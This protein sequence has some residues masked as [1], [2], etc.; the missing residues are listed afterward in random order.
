MTA[1]DLHRPIEGDVLDL[2]IADHY[3][4]EDLLRHMRGPVAD[5]DAARQAFAAVHVAHAEAEEKLVY[6][7]LRRNAEDVSAHDA[8]HGEEEHAQ[9]NDAL[10]RVM[11]LKGV[12]TAAYDEAMTDLS[13]LVCHHLAEEELT[14]LT[15]SRA[16]VSETLRAE[17]GKKFA[18][19]RNRQIDDSCG[20]LTNLRRIVKEA[21]K[22]GLLEDEEAEIKE[23]KGES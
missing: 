21:E 5:R 19:E 6:P 2:I 12:D 13:A 22:E 9:G 23:A 3:L 17:L 10:L 1:F 7:A 16:E 20:S 4:M 14:I 15:P 18:A 11:E 8:E